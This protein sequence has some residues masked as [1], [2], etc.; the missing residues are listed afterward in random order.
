VTDSFGD[1]LDAIGD[2]LGF[3]PFSNG[4]HDD[5]GDQPRRRRFREF[6][7][8]G[9]LPAG[10]ATEDGVALHYV[11]TRLHEAVSVLADRNAWFVTAD[12]PG[13]YRQEAVPARCWV[14]PLGSGQ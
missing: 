7:A 2:G 13:R 14:P 11:G 9:T 6:I 12:G 8:A 5:L 4:V 10:Y 3:L 1:D